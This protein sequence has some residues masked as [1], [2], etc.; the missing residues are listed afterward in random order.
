M[1]A[2]GAPS[3]AME[4]P[5]QRAQQLFKCRLIPDGEIAKCAS[6]EDLR[7]EM[8]LVLREALPELPKPKYEKS[9]KTS[10]FTGRLDAIHQGVVIEYKKPKLL[11][12][13]AERDKALGQLCGYLERLGL[14][15][16][17]RPDE[18]AP[19]YTQEQE[20]KL[21][22]NVGLATDGGHFLFVQRRAKKWHPQ[23][24]ELDADTVELL[25][26]WLR[27]MQRK[28]LSPENLLADFGPQTAHAAEVIKVLVQLVHEGTHPKANVVFEEWKRIFGI[29]YGEEQLHRT[30]RADE[31]KAL[32]AAYKLDLGVEFAVLL[33]A[34]HTYYALLM[35]LLATEVIVAQ[36]R[37][38]NT[39]IGTLTRSTLKG[40]LGRLESGE[41]LE[42]LNFRNV[43]EQDFFGWYP[44][45]WSKELQDALW[46]FVQTL[47]AYDV[48]SFQL[49]P[50]RARDLLKDL[51]HG[52]IPEAVRHALGE[53]YTPDWLAEHTVALA[54]YDGDP[55]KAFL[56]PSCGSGTFLIQAI[57][58]VRQ[59]LADHSVQWGSPE[60]KAEAVELIRHNI[61]GFD[62]NPLAVIASRTNYL[63]ALRPL[64]AYRKS[65]AFE[66]PVYLTD[67]VLLPGRV[68]SQ[69]DL[70][71][72]DTLPF[73]MTVGTFH[74][75][76]EVVHK[77]V[78]SDLMNIL[79]DA[80]AHGHS[81]ASFVARAVK[82][83]KLSDRD[84]LRTSLEELFGAMKT[85]DDQGK[86]RIWAK[87]IRNRYAALFFHHHFDYVVGK[88]PHVNWE[89]LTPEW[90]KAAEKEYQRY[91]LFTLA[92][93]ESRHGGGKK[94][95]AALFTY[96][97]IDHFLK[98]KGVFAMVLHVSLVKTSGAGEGFRRFQL[99]DGES[100]AIEEAHD[101][102][103]FQPF[104]THS[105]MKIKTRTLTLRAVKDKRTK[106]PIPYH[107]WTKTQRGFI[108]GGLTWEEAAERLE[109]EEHAATP[110]RGNSGEAALTPWL[111]VPTA[112]LRQCRKIIAPANYEQHYRGHAGFYT[113][114]LNG[115]FFLEV[116]ERES[117]GTVIVRNMH[118]VGKIKCPQVQTAIEADVV[119]RL[120]RGRDI[121]RWKAS[122][123]GHVLIVQDP[124]AKKG[125]PVDWMQQTH[126]LTWA[127]LKRFEALLRERA[128]FK[129]FY[130]TGVD[131]FYSMYDI[132]TYTFAPYRVTWMDISDVMKAVVLSGDTGNDM[133]LPEHGAMFAETDSEE[134]AHYLC[135]VVNSGPFNTVVTGYAVD[136][137]LS[138][139]PLE[140]IRVPKF[141]PG[142]AVHAELSGIS[143]EAHELAAKDAAKQ[144]SQVQKKV[145]KVAKKLW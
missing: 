10:T 65:T 20:E 93:L 120:L 116:L 76:Q 99:G 39:F 3:T 11:K 138:T 17:A 53:Y 12:S 42:Q 41:I 57:R 26:V 18:D 121:A 106:Y 118:D 144:L 114:G 90:R 112:K 132:G 67:S 71:S 145:D 136:N 19:G 2:V 28:D 23:A 33:F 43:I 49:E 15:D 131:P 140:N 63:F 95:I 73:P 133:I 75:P 134:E 130:D 59:W 117:D 54:G 38:G 22:A 6:E 29:V 139:H 14:G 66:I 107:V 78:V 115:A 98:T 100:F 101:F 64:L 135:A 74:L 50:D 88:P 105:K 25:L 102:R 87:L 128:A 4:A 86:N 129:K 5:A 94:D 34:I 1:L 44:E 21:A 141:D 55:R 72:Q 35:K 126:P 108:P 127:Y 96:A 84:V 47:K 85:L 58:K 122:P 82:D 46:G 16:D 30:S 104:Q 142:D 92:G 137:H 91:G 80:I 52:L 89:A 125:Y 103:R 56:D 111:T 9:L 27:A 79:H 62:L 83:L 7:V 109:S 60:K 124:K 110:L 37:L 8:E 48:T 61:V 51:Y 45:A 143:V 123:S 24:R 40:E 81:K 68:E 13:A 69:A 97:V 113:G 77:R 31:T 32:T 36:G 70:F 119:Y